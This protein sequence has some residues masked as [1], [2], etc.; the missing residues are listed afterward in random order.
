[1]ALKLRNR[2]DPDIQRSDGRTHWAE[3]TEAAKVRGENG[4]HVLGDRTK[5][6]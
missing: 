2:K 5:V 1:M 3:G 4:L 6:M